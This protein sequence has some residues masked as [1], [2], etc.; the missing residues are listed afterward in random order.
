MTRFSLCHFHRFVESRGEI[1]R[2]VSNISLE[3]LHLRYSFAN[4]IRLVIHM[5]PIDANRAPV[6]R[7]LLNVKE[8]DSVAGE[9]IFGGI[10]PEIRVVFVVNCVDLVA[11]NKPIKMW[12]FHG[13]DAVVGENGFHPRVGREIHRVV[14]DDLRPPG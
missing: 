10:E 12:E 1:E 3:L 7:Q 4:R 6:R 14:Q 2:I 9:S 13:D 8:R 5:L 11:L